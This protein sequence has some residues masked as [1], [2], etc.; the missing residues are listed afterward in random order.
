VRQFGQAM[1]HGC[2]LPGLLRP[3]VLALAILGPDASV[4]RADDTLIGTWNIQVH[5]GT[6]E[7]DYGRIDIRREEGGLVGDMT[8]TDVSAEITATEFC[9]VWPG[10]PVISIYCVV[11]TPDPA[12]YAADNL[13]MRR[14]SLDRLEGRMLSTTEGPATMTRGEAPTS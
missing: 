1:R 2:R 5:G 4:A 12:T 7:G 9:Q 6:A 11:L 13:S 3:V 10:D 14:V 8:F